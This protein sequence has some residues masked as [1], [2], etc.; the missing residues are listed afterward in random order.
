MKVFGAVLIFTAAIWL[1]KELA[2]NLSDRPKQLRLLRTALQTLEAEITYGYTPLHESADNLS[3]RIQEPISELFSLF[4]S[5]LVASEIDARTAWQES[6]DDIWP[7]TALKEPEYEVLLAFGE[8]VGR[9]DRQ[10]EQK[11]ILLALTHL[12]QQEEEARDKQ[13]KYEGMMKSLC[14]LGGLLIILLLF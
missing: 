3:R 10:T 7:K 11:H 12:K 5:R 13:K 4:S 6:L 9:H 14:I 1:G 2:K 8:T